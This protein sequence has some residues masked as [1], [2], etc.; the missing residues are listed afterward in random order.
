[1]TAQPGN[2]S[3]LHHGFGAGSALR[4]FLDPRCD[5]STPDL[6]GDS[7]LDGGAGAAIDGLSIASDDLPI[8]IPSLDTAAI[9]DMP[10]ESDYP[11]SD[12]EWDEVTEQERC[13][14]DRLFRKETRE[15][16]AFEARFDGAGT[17][18]AAPMFGTAPPSSPREMAHTLFT[19]PTQDD[20][21]T[22]ILAELTQR[23]GVR[24]RLL[25]DV[26][27][28]STWREAPLRTL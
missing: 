23:Y 7:R 26:V 27:D 14:A 2:H 20:L 4:D 11:D 25:G 1:V 10:A 18:A 24:V 22:D 3:W 19:T 17:D 13:S 8:T 9:Y 28:D 6:F 15:I 21:M 5:R 16:E 12:S